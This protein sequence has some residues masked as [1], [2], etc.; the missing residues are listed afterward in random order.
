MRRFTL[1]LLLAVGCRSAGVGTPSA[2]SKSPGAAS[3]TVAIDRFIAAGNA[4]DVQALLAA[5]GDENG[6]RRDHETT[7]A[8]RAEDERNA[9]ILIC[10]LK[11]TTHQIQD[12]K[13]G[14]G[15]RTFYDVDMTQGT[16]HARVRFTVAETPSRQ[17]FVADFD[18]VTMQH[19]GFC[20][21]KK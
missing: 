3:Q 18:V 15:G 17:Y 2:G 4:Q 20:S 8:E 12:S 10:H 6:S 1:L 14:A 5:W 9:I 7:A 13:P 19:A 11:N 16:A 21:N